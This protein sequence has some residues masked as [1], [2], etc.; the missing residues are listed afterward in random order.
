MFYMLH[1]KQYYSIAW[2]YMAQKSE[3]SSEKNYLI[4]FN[5]QMQWHS[6]MCH[7]GI[8]TFWGHNILDSDCLKKYCQNKCKHVHEINLLQ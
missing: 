5:N 4:L 2:L 8:N 1:P 7:L 6:Y 3:I